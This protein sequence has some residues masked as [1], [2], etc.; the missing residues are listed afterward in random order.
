M[1][2]ERRRLLVVGAGPA[3]IAAALWLHDLEVPFD[4][5]S[6]DQRPGGTLLR[7]GNPIVTHPGRATQSGTEM[8][9][10]MAAQLAEHGLTPQ[11]GTR[12][13]HVHRLADGWR[14]NWEGSDGLGDSALPGLATWQAV[15]LCT[16][17]RPRMLGMPDEHAWL[18]NGLEVSVTRTRDRYRDQEVVVVGGGDAALEGALLLTE[19]T[20]RVHLVHRRDQFRAQRRFLE[21]VRAH[22]S[23]TLHTPEEVSHLV[24]ENR[25]IAGLA[26]R[27]GA[28]VRATGVF[29][30]VGVR[31]ALP[32]GLPESVT[33]TT[34]Y[35]Q[36]DRGGRTVA[37]GLYAAGDVT[38]ELHQSVSAA[39]GDAARAVAALLADQ[40]WR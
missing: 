9:D 13:T 20:A 18:G 30:R 21:R 29:V 15:L 28:T 17:T 23:I 2:A 24:V 33:G 16:G 11:W 3:G 5:V 7:V 12:V 35:L 10:A 25:Q 22:P 27:S 37:H 1:A 40:G 34:G 4:W 38:G 32:D 26:L 31:A 19:V 39:S 8:A 6:A 14:V 36:V